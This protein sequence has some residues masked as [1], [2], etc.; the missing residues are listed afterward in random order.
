MLLPSRWDIALVGIGKKVKGG[1]VH[2]PSV[3]LVD[4]FL[5]AS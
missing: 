4:G 3:M 1:V 2:R 5:P